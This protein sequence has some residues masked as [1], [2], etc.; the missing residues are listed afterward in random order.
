MEL[1]VQA[2]EELQAA[3]QRLTIESENEYHQDEV[4]QAKWR[5]MGALG[6]IHN[7]AIWLRAST[8]QY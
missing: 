4:T 2:A 8:E 6:K 5:E 3:E 1:A 7:I